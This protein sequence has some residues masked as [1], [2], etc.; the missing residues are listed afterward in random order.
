MW[1]Y[2][3]QL[4]MVWAKNVMLVYAQTEQQLWQKFYSGVV[5]RVKEV[6]SYCKAPHC[7]SHYKMLATK[8]ISWI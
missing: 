8:K 2:G 7:I 6:A 1:K 4:D 5:A 3:T